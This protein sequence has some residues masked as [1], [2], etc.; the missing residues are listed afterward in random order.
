MARLSFLLVS[1]L[2]L[3]VGIATAASAVV[4]LIPKNFDKVILKSGKPALV[5]FFAP[6]CGH[7]KNLAPVYEELGQVFAH[8]EDKVTIGKVDADEH[9]DLGKKF[10][11]QGFPTLKWFDGTS[12][13][14]VDYNGGRDLESL[15]A[16]ITEK[17]GIKPRGPKKEPSQVEMLTDSTFKTTIGGDKDVLVAFTAPWCGHCKSLAPTWETLAKDFA[18]EPNVVI[19]KVDA[20]AE[21]AKATAKE[22]GVTGY[23]TIKFFPKGSKEGIP[24]SG[25]RSEEAL[26]E[27]LN[28]QTGTHRVVGGGLDE[29]AGTI[30]TVDEL[31]AKYTS[32]QNL[33]ELVGEVKK[34]TKGLQDKY[35]EYYVKVAE[36][37][38]KNKEYAG[39][40]F[41]RL[42]KIIA[43]GGS[44]PEK[45]D[46]LISR[47]NVLRQFLPHEKEDVDMKDEL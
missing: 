14:P 22:Q 29:K 18:L 16:F 17:T 7:C 32:S 37:L 5:E 27:F 33:E 35:A 31:V 4:D 46:D 34:A 43:K 8:A 38:G 25:A 9:R 41:A 26:I 36:K 47:S 2:A 20:E 40:E 24:Y 13:K 44:A 39:K 30:P 11:I 6:W 3:L 42:K 10:G 1:C 12:D 19:A 15:T 28:T 45:I 21:N 23:P